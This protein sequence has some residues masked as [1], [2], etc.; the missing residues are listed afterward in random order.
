MTG[1]AFK[2]S[3]AE[4]PLGTPVSIFGPVGNFTLPVAATASVV[5]IAGG[6]GITPFRSMVLDA[7]RRRP[8][9]ITLIYSNRIPSAP[10]SRVA[11]V[12]CPSIT[13]FR[14]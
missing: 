5:F 2:R 12:G 14:Q 10:L 13:T 8:H 6:I 3:L 9:R 1:S 11:T 4:A 7:V